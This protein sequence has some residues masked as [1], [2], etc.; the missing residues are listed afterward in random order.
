MSVTQDYKVLTLTD[1]ENSAV[2]AVRAALASYEVMLKVY[3]LDETIEAQ[4]RH[5]AGLLADIQSALAKVR[6]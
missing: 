6:A 2:S 5:V 3:L 1:C 4:A